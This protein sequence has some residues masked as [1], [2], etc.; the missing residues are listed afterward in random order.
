MIREGDKVWVIPNPGGEPHPAIVVHLSADGK[1][2]VVMPGTGT[3]P[4]DIPHVLVDPSRR[5][6]MSLRL[7]K[8]TYFYQTAVCVRN[9]EELIV[10]DTPALRCPI[11]M[12][13]RF[14]ALARAGAQAKL[15]AKDLREWWPDA[16]AGPAPI[17]GAPTTT[18]ANLPL[19]PD[20]ASSPA[21]QAAAAGRASRDG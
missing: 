6:G 16:E 11:V 19:D 14:Q 8:K 10:R 9:I 3:G 17:M 13:P 7:S 5:V 12:W 2:A 15:S 21:E 20:T 4:R 1:R 18:E